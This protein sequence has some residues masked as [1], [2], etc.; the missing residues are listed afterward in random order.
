VKLY[1]IIYHD[2][3]SL[4]DE[5]SKIA[6]QRDAIPDSTAFFNICSCSTDFSML[7]HAASIIEDIFPGAPY[8]G[9]STYNNIVN[10][11]NV[12]ESMTICCWLFEDTRSYVHVGQLPLAETN[13]QGI[14]AG[15]IITKEVN[16]LSYVRA[17]Q[18]FTTLELSSMTELCDQLGA[19]NP[20][21]HLAGGAAFFP[22][23]N[24]PDA[25]VIS[26][27]GTC[28]D[29]SIVY[30][31]LCGPRLH[32]TSLFISGW[33]PL[34]RELQVTKSEGNIV[35]EFD[36]K[37]AFEAY[38]HY[39]HAENDESFANTI[40][41]FPLAFQQDGVSITRE[42][43]FCTPEGSLVLTSD[44]SNHAPCVLPMATPMPSCAMHAK[45]QRSFVASSPKA[46]WRYHALRVMCSGAIK[47]HRRPAPSKKSL[48][49]TACIQPRNS[50]ARGHRCTRTTYRS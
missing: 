1:Q 24:K 25:R 39:L 15:S 30:A 41:A 44:I 23:I 6:A 29:K 19:L 10:A 50:S 46:F 20:S 42:P 2:D 27:A 14:N 38:R 18:L 8:I 36:G 17:V 45:P 3:E 49:R 13:E 35:H 37:P 31:A 34:G 33:K 26:S 5:L 32:V 11:E 12:P 7:T 16:G 43:I 48:P 4:K 47:S 22:V 21:I 40:R 9:A 28:A